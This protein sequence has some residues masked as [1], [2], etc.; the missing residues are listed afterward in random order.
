[1]TWKPVVP[2]KI[3]CLSWKIYFK[4]VATSD[5]LQKKGFSLANRC[6]LCNSNTES[7][8]HLFINCEFSY[9]VWTLLS[10]KLS[11]HGPLPSN[12]VGFIKGWKGLNCVT[13]FQSAMKVI[14]QAAF[15][16]IW[17]ERNDR[18]FRKLLNP[19][20]FTLR[21]IWFAAGDWLLAASCFT[22]SELSGW[23]R[24]LFDNG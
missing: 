1:M 5:N 17:K 7:V 14:L 3:A 20:K 15:W 16:F 9:K 18:I 23:R 11:F 22:T 2:S 12:V 8:D 4:K 21:K 13:S 24:M 6:V 19:P 10:S